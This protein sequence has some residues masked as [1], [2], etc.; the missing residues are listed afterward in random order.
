MSPPSSPLILPF[1]GVLTFLIAAGLRYF[2]FEDTVLGEKAFLE[3]V[4]LTNLPLP[5]NPYPSPSAV[6][7]AHRACRSLNDTLPGVVAFPGQD[8]AV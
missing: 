4:G 2:A 1:M 8:I 6:H 3:P 7:A 5:R